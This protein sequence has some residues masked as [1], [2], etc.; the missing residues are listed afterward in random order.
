MC[1]EKRVMGKGEDVEKAVQRRHRRPSSFHYFFRFS[2]LV[3]RA[4]FWRREAAPL[5]YIQG[6]S[7]S[8]MGFGKVN[9]MVCKIALT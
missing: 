9:F 8:Q 6:T 7:N 1:S 3:W 5:V 2:F 4:F